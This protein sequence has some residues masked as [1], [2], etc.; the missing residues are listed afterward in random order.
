MLPPPSL[1][2][3]ALQGADTGW[4]YQWQLP[5]EPV[6]MSAEVQSPLSRRT[7]LPK[8]LGILLCSS[9][10]I[11]QLAEAQLQQG[12]AAS[13]GLVSG[14]LFCVGLQLLEEG[15]SSLTA[16]CEKLKIHRQDLNIAR[17]VLQQSTCSLHPPT[18]H[19]CW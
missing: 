12:L 5:L 15:F 7:L 4:A 16:G 9:E 8:H 10:R 3:P 6:G 2:P 18:G 17:C 19:E 11:I 14:A 1:M 13:Q